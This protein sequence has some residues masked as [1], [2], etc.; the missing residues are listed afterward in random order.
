MRTKKLSYRD[1]LLR[2][3]Q[4]VAATA[5]SEQSSLD[6]DGPV[7]D[8]DVLPGDATATPRSSD[9]QSAGS[10]RDSLSEP[11]SST[12]DASVERVLKRRLNHGANT[13]RAAAVRPRDDPPARPA[14]KETQGRPKPDVT[15]KR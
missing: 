12:D 1:A 9:S 6:W 5:S 8:L 11:V 15:K 13:A 7:S 10:L 14:K 3:R 2:P 4:S